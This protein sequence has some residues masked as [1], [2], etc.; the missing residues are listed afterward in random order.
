MNNPQRL[1]ADEKTIFEFVE[2][3]GDNLTE[4]DGVKVYFSYLENLLVYDTTDPHSEA[5][6]R[7]SMDLVETF[8][9]SKSKQNYLLEYL[10]KVIKK[11]QDICCYRNNSEFFEV[12]IRK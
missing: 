12:L 5:Y 8:L 3:I 4:N 6:C 2:S 7:R 11:F 1:L 10:P 9:S